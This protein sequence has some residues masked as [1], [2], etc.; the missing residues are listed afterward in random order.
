MKSFLVFDGNNIFHKNY[1]VVKKHGTPSEAVDM[2]ISQSF[3]DFKY[4]FEK[5][6]PTMTMIAFDSKSNWRKDYTRSEKCHTDKIYKANR[7]EKMTKKEKEV[8]KLLDE[9]I[10]EI[11]LFLKNYSKLII[12]W[13]D[14]LE[15][16]DM[17]SGV[18][19]IFGNSEYDINIV[20]SDT[21]Y[22]QFYRYSNVKIINPLAHGKDRNLAE[23][24][25]DAELFLFE[26]IIRG[27]RKDNV[28]S[29]YPRVRKAKILEAYYDELKRT[30]MMNHIFSETFY[31][32]KVDDYVTREFVVNDLFEENRLLLDLNAQPDNIR[33]L[34]DSIVEREI[35]KKRKT[36]FMKFLQL[37]NRRELNN[38][39]ARPRA[40][41]P[42][43]ENK[44]L[45]KD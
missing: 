14:G 42:L 29:A 33:E 44:N 25:N 32:E 2:A 16:D 10:Q 26:K 37:A 5:Y 35:V 11:A 23:W 41:L 1:H 39:L 38:I 24:N 12:L 21:D 3:L 43:L 40:L 17:A 8:K 45:S 7:S 30:N 20:S 6:K 18:C 13:E 31:D 36:N 15:A 28:R 9:A 19:R 22:L 4:Y 27:D 34:I